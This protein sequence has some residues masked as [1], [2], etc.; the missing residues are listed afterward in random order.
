MKRLLTALVAMA[1][2]ATGCGG[3]QPNQP[4]AGG[5]QA[6][7]AG[8]GRLTIATGNSGGVY[9]VLGGGLAQLISNNTGLKATAAE[10]GASVQNIQQL[11]DGTYDIAFS[12]ADTAAD[13][14]QGKG[15]FEGK[16]QKVQALTRLYPNST[17]VL[18]RTDSGINSIADMRGKRIS[19]GSPKSGTEV[20]A[21]RLLQS[22][23]LNPDTDVQAQR[24]DL[25]KTADGIKSG[26]I[27][28]LVW[29]GGLPTAQITDITTTM[30]GQVKFIDITPQLAALKQINT[31]YDTGTIPAATYGQP[32]DVPTI[33]V[34]N[35][36]L[37][38]ED[39][40]ASDACA[41]TKLMF[42]K[43]ADLES[44]HPSAKEITRENATRTE[45]V[46]LHPG[47]QQA[48]ATS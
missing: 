21:N 6:C 27:D 47:A 22:A 17:Q 11:V 28:G 37:V 15:S 32:A 23:G 26:T 45:P 30:K 36:L 24:L 35:L 12:L 29:S 33:V 19:T 20:I 7:E 14:V 3:K 31:V 13:A 34:P 16:P 8:S 10:T 2:V 1:L 41:I 40:P 18:V 43:R 42:D 38:R 48:L 44:V 5:S 39:F 4:A 46:P 25:A 9:Y